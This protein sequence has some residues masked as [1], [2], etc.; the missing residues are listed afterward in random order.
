MNGTTT[1]QSASIA[2]ILAALRAA[3]GEPG[4]GASQPPIDELV[5]TILSQHT[6]DINTA[7]A[8]ASL[9]ATFP[10]WEEVV[11][12]PTEL[13]ADAIRSGGL[14][15]VKAPRIQQALRDVRS[16][17]GSFD[18]TFLNELNPV[19][20]RAW[21]TELHGVGPKTA[22]CVL[23]F[24]LNQ[25]VMPVDTHVHRVSLRLGLVP[26]KTSADRAHALLEAQIP[27]DEMYAAHMLFIQ[28]G[29]RTCLAR[30]PRCRECVLVQWCPAA[31]T[32]LNNS[33]D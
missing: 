19:A 26:P 31:T 27:P 22:S 18:L 2:E 29:R 7:R 14:A 15:E 1:T 32:F 9:V 21:L 16:R 17:T 13:V 5:Q 4:R 8:F 11:D 30:A 33:S 23:L 24:S 25:P 20:A 6:S 12:A 10:T 3:Y 28:H